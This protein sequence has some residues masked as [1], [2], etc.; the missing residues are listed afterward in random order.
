VNI[1]STLPSPPPAKGVGTTDTPAGVLIG[2][3]VNQ[4][5]LAGVDVDQAAAAVGADPEDLFDFFVDWALT[6]IKQPAARHLT[7][8]AR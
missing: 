2:A 8:V 3:L 4:L 5:H 6:Q 7:A 1:V